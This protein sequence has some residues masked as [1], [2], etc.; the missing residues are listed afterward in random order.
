M[1]FDLW[2]NSNGVLEETMAARNGW[3]VLHCKTR[4]DCP[5]YPNHGRTCLAITGTMC[6]GE[7][8][9]SYT[10]KVAECRAKCEF[11]KDI[12]DGVFEKGGAV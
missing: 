1:L 7:K 2:R 9:G 8:Q 12:I 6:R 4:E 5:A 3:E 10:E 11:F